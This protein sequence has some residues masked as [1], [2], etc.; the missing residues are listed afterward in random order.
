M[1]QGTHDQNSTFLIRRSQQIV[2]N[3]LNPSVKDTIANLKRVAFL[4][5]FH[6]ALR[7]ERHKHENLSN[8]RFSEFFFQKLTDLALANHYFT[9]KNYLP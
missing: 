8:K 9:L 3:S 1:S 6:E 2:F 5:K 7:A 4:H